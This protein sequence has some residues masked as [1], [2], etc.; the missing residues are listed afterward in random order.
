[1]RGKRHCLETIYYI[2]HIWSSDKG[3]V[4]NG[5]R[6]IIRNKS[7]LTCLQQKSQWAKR[8]WRHS[9]FIE[10]IAQYMNEDKKPTQLGKT[11]CLISK[12]C[13]TPLTNR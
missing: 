6:G 13:G 12:R 11:S 7:K 2:Q 4:S 5:I 1:M 10:I 9:I 3:N 8:I